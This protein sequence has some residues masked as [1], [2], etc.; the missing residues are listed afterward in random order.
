MRRVAVTGASGF[1][2]RALLRALRARGF[3]V[4]AL[5]RTPQTLRVGRDIEVR[6][7]DPEDASPNPAAFEGADA[8]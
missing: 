1:V 6:R 2:G 8:V 3:G 7:F 5:S 4:I